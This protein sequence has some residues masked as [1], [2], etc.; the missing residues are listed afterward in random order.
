MEGQATEAIEQK[1]IKISA[2]T[3]TTYHR[4]LIPV[5]PVEEFGT[6]FLFLIVANSYRKIV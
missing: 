6:V 4:E 2:A 1:D 3:C 5:F